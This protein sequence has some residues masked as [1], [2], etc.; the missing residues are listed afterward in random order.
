MTRASD[1]GPV[2]VVPVETRTPFSFLMSPT[3]RAVP[4]S[5]VIE[6]RMFGM[7]KGT[8]AVCITDID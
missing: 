1:T 7:I 3:S 2:T 8:M 5:R 6:K 4:P